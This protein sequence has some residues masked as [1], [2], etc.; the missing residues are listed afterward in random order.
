MNKQEYI[1][2]VKKAKRIFVFPVIFDHSS[3][4]FRVS[5]RQASSMF[6]LIPETATIHAQWADD[7]EQFLLIGCKR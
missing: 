5:K 1:Q 7:E 4:G 6:R 2:A 3:R